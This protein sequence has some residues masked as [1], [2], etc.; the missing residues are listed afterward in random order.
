VI[1]LG[2]VGCY[3]PINIEL[4]D[5]QAQIVVNTTLSPD[6]TFN[7]SLVRTNEV[8]GDKEVKAIS[9][10]DISVFEAGQLLAQLT[11]PTIGEDGQATPVFR[12]E[13]KKPK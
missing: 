8:L 11:I 1:L 3:Q 2:F 5:N 12:H 10:A 4:P 13:S 9:E 6:S 7:L